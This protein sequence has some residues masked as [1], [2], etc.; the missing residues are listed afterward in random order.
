MYIRRRA[1]RVNLTNQPSRLLLHFFTDTGTSFMVPADVPVSSV[2]LFTDT[3]TGA[4]VKAAL[5]ACAA[6][7]MLSYQG[8]FGQQ[9]QEQATIPATVAKMIKSSTTK[10]NVL[11]CGEDTKH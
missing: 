6:Q 8:Q 2:L 9:A 4:V 3:A 10:P 7:H 5:R 1:A 11:I